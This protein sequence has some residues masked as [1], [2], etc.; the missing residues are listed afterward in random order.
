MKIL[1][2]QEAIKLRRKGLTYKEIG[3]RLSVSKGSLSLW[4]RDV[5]HTPSEKS[6]Q[7]R[8]A[9]INAGLVLHKRKLERIARIKKE[10]MQEIAHIKPDLFKLLG[11][12]AYWTEGSRT[13]D[14]VVAFTNTDP[15]FIRFTLK[16]L[17][18]ICAVPEEKLRLHLRIHPGT[19]RIKAEG[20]WSRVTK[21][22]KRKFYKTTVKTSGSGGRR[23]NKISNGI[24]SIKVCDTDL[25]YRIMGW[26]DGLID[27]ANL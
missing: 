12:I 8:T 9:S 16:W 11:T 22:P 13:H 5:S 10:A 2:R 15:R 7:R 4:L 19:N 26:I 21:I 27:N 23:Y 18:E 24:V 20:Y 17:R 3:E 1:E 14:H 25:F 6:M